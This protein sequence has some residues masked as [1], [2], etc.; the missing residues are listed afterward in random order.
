MKVAENVYALKSTR[1]A[2]AYI[3][4]GEE[5]ILVDT[6]LMWQGKKIIKELI[7]MNIKLEDIKHIVLTHHDLDH[8]GNVYMLQRLTKARVWASSEDIPYIMGN[9]ERPGIKKL[10]SF[11]F[12]VKKPE[13]IE[14]YSTSQQIDGIEIIKTPGHTP[15]HVCVLYKD[16]LFAGDLVKNKNGQLR[17]YPNMNWDEALLMNSIKGI[18]GIRFNW[19]C[20]AHGEPIERGNQWK[21]M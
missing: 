21:D 19:V 7:A 15:G 6:G 16:I 18:S 3:I 10:F 4:L 1:G 11:V 2:Y 17:P 13:K 5:I 9:K 20:P 14:S 8:I 12:R